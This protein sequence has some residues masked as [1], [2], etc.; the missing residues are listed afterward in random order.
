MT[1]DHSHRPAT[2]AVVLAFVLVYISWGTTFLAIREGVHNQQ[3]PPALFGGTRVALAGVGVLGF[4]ALRGEGIRF[5]WLEFRRA[6]LTGLVLS[7]GGTRSS[8]AAVRTRR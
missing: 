4:L 5:A 3:L 8:A 6:V 1:Q 2:W 7:D